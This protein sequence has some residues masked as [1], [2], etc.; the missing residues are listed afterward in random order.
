YESFG[1]WC[2]EGKY[3]YEIGIPEDGEYEVFVGGDPSTGSGQWFEEGRH[4]L[5]LDRPE[6]ENLV[7]EEVSVEGLAYYGEIDK[8]REGETYRVSLDYRVEGSK[9][10][11]E[12]DFI[13]LEDRAI[14]LRVGL[15]DTFGRWERFERTV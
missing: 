3:C 9:G 6:P 11:A 2:E 13:F 5:M 10:S 12:L 4:R 7:R 1:G 15:G 8:W 14:L